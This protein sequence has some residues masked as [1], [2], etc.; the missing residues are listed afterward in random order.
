MDDIN[1]L[2]ESLRAIA[3]E[4]LRLR[5]GDLAIFEAAIARGALDHELHRLRLTEQSAARAL[6]GLGVPDEAF[7]RIIDKWIV[8]RPQVQPVALVSSSTA[9]A[10]PSDEKT[11]GTA[12]E[13]HWKMRV[14]AEAAAH[15]KRL[16][17]SGCNPTRASIR[18]HLVTWCVDNKVKTKLD[19]NPSDGY[20]R[21]H[22]LA[23][24]HWTPP[25]D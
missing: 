11:E 12:Q 4:R 20:L 2:R 10:T 25:A 8:G 17:Q 5:P 19:I 1:V 24:R 21:T 18:P 14:Q 6:A 13:L 16:R 7:I 3:A 23:K 15:W 9:P 22:V